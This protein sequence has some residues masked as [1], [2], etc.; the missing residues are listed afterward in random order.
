MWPKLE[1]L[2]TGTHNSTLQ[3][4]INFKGYQRIDE[5]TTINI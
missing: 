5:W 4:K 3:L 1:L 2:E